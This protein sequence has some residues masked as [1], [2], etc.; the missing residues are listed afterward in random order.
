MGRTSLITTGALLWTFALAAGV[1][2]AKPLALVEAKKAG[3][4]ASNCQYCHSTA[5]PKKETFKPD[6]LNER[7]KFLLMDMQQRNLK[8]PDLAKLKDYKSEK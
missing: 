1:A 2:S 6:E 7:G 5:Q 8:A 4:P 3:F